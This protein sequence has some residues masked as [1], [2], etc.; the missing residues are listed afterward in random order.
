MNPIECKKIN[1]RWIEM[2]R[3]DEQ[4]LNFCNFHLCEVENI[5]NLLGENFQCEILLKAKKDNQ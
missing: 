3:E 4:R 5:S 1:C 2:I